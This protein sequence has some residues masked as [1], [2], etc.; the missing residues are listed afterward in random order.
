MTSKWSAVATLAFCRFR[1]PLG[2]FCRALLIDVRW[3][4]KP[5]R[6]KAVA[7]FMSFGSTASHGP[8]LAVC[9]LPACGKGNFGRGRV[10]LCRSVPWAT[11]FAKRSCV[12]GLRAILAPL[13]ASRLSCAEH[14][15]D[16]LAVRLA[17]AID[18]MD[19]RPS[20]LVID[21]LRG[22]AEREIFAACWGD[23]SAW[24]NFRRC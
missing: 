3:G 24:S 10:P 12:V 18:G 9:G 1:R 16:V 6:T 19:D 4:K 23:A 15:D 2:R 22:V 5:S 21:G 14:G 20:L 13:G 11:W 8:V 7:P 17:D